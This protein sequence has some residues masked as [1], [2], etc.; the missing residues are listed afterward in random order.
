VL[1][2]IFRVYASLIF[3]V[4]SSGC[5][6]PTAALTI[7]CRCLASPKQSF[8]GLSPVFYCPNFWDSLNL[9]G[10]VSVFISPSNRVAQLYPQTLGSFQSP[11]MTLK[12]TVEAFLP[13]STLA[14]FA[15]P[16]KSKSSYNWRSVRLGVEPT[17]DLRPDINS[18]CKLLSCLCW[19][20][21]LTS[22]RV[23]LSSVTVSNICS[24]SSS[25]HLYFPFFCTLHVTDVLCIYNIYTAS[26]SLGLVQQ[27]MLNYL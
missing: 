11:I 20:S 26:V 8:S 12:V 19:A 6:L 7:Y 24:L 15:W 14:G 16:P 18:V 3:L 17:V 2:W 22:G 10:Q 1:I 27:I 21:S 25:F 23:Y 5:F 4:E 9:E 13:V